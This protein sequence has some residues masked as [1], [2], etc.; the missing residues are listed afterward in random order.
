MKKIAL[1]IIMALGFVA[2]CSNVEKETM[3][4]VKNNLKDPESAQFKDVDGYCGEVNVK[5]S[6]G[7]YTGFKRFISVDG[8]TVI[9]SN[10]DDPLEF[11]LGWEAYCSKN[12]SSNDERAACISD[13]KTAASAFKAKY[14]LVSIGDAKHSTRSAEDTPQSIKHIDKII[15][16][17]YASKSKNSDMYALEVINKCLKH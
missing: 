6:Y 2:G 17:A 4:A 11:A 8:S 14:N 3:A 9:E 16:D 12:K 1:T 10:D 13:A 7:G 15:D 5:N